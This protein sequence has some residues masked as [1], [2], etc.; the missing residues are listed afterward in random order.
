[1]ALLCVRDCVR[2][3][4]Q[5]LHRRFAGLFELCRAQAHRA[6]EQDTE[7][8]NRRHRLV[9]CDTLV[10]VLQRGEQQRSIRFA[11]IAVEQLVDI[12]K[13]LAEMAIAA[14]QFVRRHGVAAE[15]QLQH[16]V[17]QARRR[18]GFQQRTEQAQRRFGR[19]LDAEA[20]LGG[21]TDGSQQ[22]HGI[23]PVALVRVADQPQHPG[24]DI[25]DAAGVIPDRKIGDVVIQRICS[26]ITA[27]HVIINVAVA[28][29]A[30]DAPFFV[31]QQQRLVI[32]IE[33]IF[34][35]PESRDFH[36]VTAKKHVREAKAPTDQAAIAEQTTHIFRVRVGGDIEILRLATKHQVAHAAPDQEG[37]VP[38]VTEPV[39]DLEGVLGDL[40]P[41]DVMLGPGDD[42]WPLFRAVCRAGQT[43]SAC[44]S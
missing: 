8:E 19:R 12:R 24:A 33:L 32:G 7:E 13:Q 15:K 2:C 27:P 26:E 31:L 39:H 34:R 18:H 6:P 20:E 1:M 30:Q 10:G 36:D 25:I 17:E 21:E 40:R 42:S 23:F 4:Q 28:V 44:V 37:L 11:R 43:V 16:L 22:A 41:R 35:C 29:I 14:Q 5:R 3:Q 38:G 9:V